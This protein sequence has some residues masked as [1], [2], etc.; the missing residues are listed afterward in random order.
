MYIDKSIF[1]IIKQ[2]DN[3]FVEKISTRLK[4]L[5]SVKVAISGFEAL[6]PLSNNRF[7][8]YELAQLQLSISRN[9]EAMQTITYALDNTPSI[10]KATLSFPKN[11]KEDQLVPLDAALLNLKGIISYELKDEKAAII[12]IKEAL[13]IFPEFVLAKQNLIALTQEAQVI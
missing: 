12:A 11:E 8:A 5:N 9:I 6:L 3:F 2:N 4:S 10:N 7:D 13:K 1:L